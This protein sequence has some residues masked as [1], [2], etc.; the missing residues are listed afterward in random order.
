MRVYLFERKN[1]MKI[2]KQMYACPTCK[3]QEK[4]NNCDFK[5]NWHISKE[6]CYF[7]SDWDIKLSINPF[8]REI[9]KILVKL[10]YYNY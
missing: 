10:G 8:Y 7:C 2:F 3:F 6:D 4:D 9:A 5:R 1:D